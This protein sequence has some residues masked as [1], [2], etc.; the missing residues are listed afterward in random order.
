MT[1][2]PET[3]KV[4]PITLA[5]RLRLAREWRDLD[6][7]QIADELGI[8]RATISNYERGISAPGKLAMNAWAVICNVDVEWLKTGD[9]DTR[10]GDGPGGVPGELSEKSR[11][12]NLQGRVISVDFGARIAA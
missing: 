9:D 3:R 8:S 4:P 10:D 2:L 1:L 7:Q 6:Q 11:T 12:D 5:V